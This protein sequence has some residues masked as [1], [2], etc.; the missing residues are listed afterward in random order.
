MCGELKGKENKV[1]YNPV[2][3]FCCQS[4]TSQ[5]WLTNKQPPTNHLRSAERCLSRAVKSRPETENQDKVREYLEMDI[6]LV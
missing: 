6:L 1:T 2:S 5:N 4:T 3:T